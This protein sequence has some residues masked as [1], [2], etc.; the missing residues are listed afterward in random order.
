MRTFRSATALAMA[1][2]LAIPATKASAATEANVNLILTSPSS[3][4]NTLSMTIDVTPSILPQKSATQKPTITGDCSA[5]FDALF[6]P[7]SHQ[8]TISDLTFNLEQPGQIALQ[9][10]TFAYSWPSFGVQENI[11][12]SNVL[13]SPYTPSTYAPTLVAGGLFPANQVSA[14]FN[15]GSFVSS[16]YAT[17]S[18]NLASNPIDAANISTSSGTVAISA[19]T[20]NG[21]LA[22]YTATVTVPLSVNQPLNGAN[23]TSQVIAT[24]TLQA[25]GTFQFDFGPRTVNWDALTGNLNIGSNWDVGFAPRSGDTAAISNSGASVLATAYSGTP[26]AVWVGEGASTSGTLTLA[27]GGSLS[28]GAMV[29]G[30]SGGSGL[31]ALSGGTLLAPSIVQDGS[32]TSSLYFNGGTLEATASNSQFISGLSAAYVQAGG[33]TINSNGFKVSVSQPLLHDPALGATPDGGLLKSGAGT[34]V[35][36]GSDTYTG[37]TRVQAGI[38]KLTSVSALPAG[39]T[40]AVGANSSSLFAPA[41]AASLT[42][43]SARAAAPVPEPS[44]L[45]LLGIGVLSLAA[46][47][48]GRRVRMPLLGH[49]R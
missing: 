41:A 33:A 24:G 49:E 11:S 1:V 38:L 42:E 15:S 21:S 12:T 40:L 30:A 23:Y 36:S 28:C 5:T 35:L 46:L 20:M 34:L 8:A 44:T 6:N 14:N 26:A 32:G 39:S 17:S 43:A 4:Y 25:S 48:T 16:G 13:F 29:L 37:G 31:L 18:Q 3:T 22:T 27:A 19:P 2:S 45:A 47:A 10:E 7:V 9:N